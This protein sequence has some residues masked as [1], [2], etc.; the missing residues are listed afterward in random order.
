MSGR[1]GV[2]ETWTQNFESLD[3]ARGKKFGLPRRQETVT[4]TAHE[5]WIVWWDF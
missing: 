1:P 3:Q 4:L 2:V 5:Y